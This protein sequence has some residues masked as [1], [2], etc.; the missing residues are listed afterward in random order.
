MV[1]I[2]LLPV[3]VSKK[4]E[5]GQQQLL[6]FLV[7][8][9]AG[10]VLN[11]I[12][13]ERKN[14]ALVELEGKLAST[15]A[16]IV[17]LDKII[18]QVKEIKSDQELLKKKLET[19]DKLKAGRVGPVRML[20]Q[21]SEII[22]RRLWLR[23]MDEKE[24]K[25]TFSGSASSIDEVSQFISKLKESKYFE[26]VELKSATAKLQG[27]F[28]IVEFEI[29]ALGKYAPGLAPPTDGGKAAPAKGKG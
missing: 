8:V 19:L 4:K 6:L 11:W 16:E 23:K 26:N 2:N 10:I 22:P 3:R 20:D 18:G 15:K 9:V 21:L 14:G 12:Y 28:K 13:H 25:V 1:R 7:L 17:K 5:A 24:G 29:S 27:S